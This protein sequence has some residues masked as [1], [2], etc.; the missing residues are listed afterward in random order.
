MLSIPHYGHIFH[1][2][3]RKCDCHMNP[4]QRKKHIKGP[5][6]CISGNVLVAIENSAQP[7]TKV[8]FES[9]SPEPILPTECGSSLKF[10]PGIGHALPSK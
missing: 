2:P 8:A 4:R 5:R 9:A 6:S 7:Q 10:E 3:P 1:N